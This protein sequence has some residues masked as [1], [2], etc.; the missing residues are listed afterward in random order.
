MFLTAHP[1]ALAID[2]VFAA[3]ADDFVPKPA[4]ASA[5]VARILNRLERIGLQRSTINDQ[6]SP[7]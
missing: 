6:A 7:N 2:R 3:G 1:A 4:I 5:L